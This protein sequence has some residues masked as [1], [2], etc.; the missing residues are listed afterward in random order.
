MIDLL[1]PIRAVQFLF[2]IITL[3][4]SGYCGFSPSLSSL[5]QIIDHHAGSNYEY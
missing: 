4:L 1:L 2:T 3:G 5:I